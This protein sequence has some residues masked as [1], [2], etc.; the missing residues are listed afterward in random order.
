LAPVVELDNERGSRGPHRPCRVAA[1]LVP[2]V[3]G[4]LLF[5]RYGLTVTFIITGALLVLAAIFMMVATPE[6]R[7]KLLDDEALSVAG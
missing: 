7:G 1:A 6:T 2:T 5:P 4:S 3:F